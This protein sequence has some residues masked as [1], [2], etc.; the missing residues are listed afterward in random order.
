MAS[1]MLT[2][3]TR[4]RLLPSGHGPRTATSLA[5]PSTAHIRGAP[6]PEGAG[7][8]ITLGTGEVLTAERGDEQHWWA[9]LPE[10]RYDVRLM[11]SVAS[12]E[13]MGP[14]SIEVAAYGVFPIPSLDF[15]R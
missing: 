5:V 11:G 6:L 14:R 1:Y 7:L 2:A 10:G 13:R 3:A 15:G 9:A 12:F 8:E 4:V